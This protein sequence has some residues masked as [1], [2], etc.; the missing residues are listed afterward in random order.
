MQKINSVNK[1]AI[2]GGGTSA[3]LT[4]A[5]L[6]NKIPHLE[7][8]IIDKEVGTPVGVG[9]GTLL[10]FDNVMKQ[11]GFEIEDWFF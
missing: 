3:W 2:V 4:A 10:S 7:I 11:C 9:E 6:S 8:T 5:M 1:I